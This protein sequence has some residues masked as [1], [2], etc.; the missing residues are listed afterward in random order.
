M[1]KVKITP[2]EMA[3][4]HTLIDSS[5]DN[6]IKGFL[7]VMTGFA[8]MGAEGKSTEDLRDLTDRLIFSFEEAVGIV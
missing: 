2:D 6:D 3:K 8:L 5:V 4:V 7:L 1:S